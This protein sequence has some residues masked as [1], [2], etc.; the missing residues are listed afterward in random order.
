MIGMQR[1]SCDVQSW[2]TTTET[3]RLAVVLQQMRHAIT[4]G[5]AL[6]QLAQK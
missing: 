5:E 6:I 1:L 3:S 2:R 4:T